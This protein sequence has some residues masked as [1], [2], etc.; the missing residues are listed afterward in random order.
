MQTSALRC[1]QGQR[2]KAQTCQHAQQ[3]KEPQLPVLQAQ[4]SLEGLPPG[5]RAEQWQQPFDHQ[6]QGHCPQQPVEQ[7]CALCA[8][9]YLR[10]A[11]A[12][13]APCPRMARKKSLPG[14]TTITSD[15][16]RKVAR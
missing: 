14:S 12:G 6:H 3:A 15:L 9:S 2:Q 1:R 5:R 16:L 11:G 7:D 8:G 4:R 13:A 10:G